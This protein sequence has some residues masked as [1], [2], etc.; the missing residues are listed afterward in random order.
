MTKKKFKHTGVQ[1]PGCKLRLFS[2][3]RYDFV[4]CD[5]KNDTFVDGGLGY[6]R[7]GGK[8]MPKI[9]V[10]NDRLDGK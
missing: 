1:C 7:Y 3:H 5:C 6:L 4:M 9:I 10:W 8:K 2:M